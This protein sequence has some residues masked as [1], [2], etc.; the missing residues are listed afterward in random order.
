MRSLYLRGKGPVS[1]C[2]R[3]YRVQLGSVL[4]IVWEGN[5]GKK[6]EGHWPCL[7]PALLE[8]G[9][10]RM[11]AAAASWSPFPARMSCW[12]VG[13]TWATMMM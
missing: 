7:S 6:R 5:L 3:A 13:C 10:A 9:L 8:Q 12:T 11:W 1:M 2:L 4:S